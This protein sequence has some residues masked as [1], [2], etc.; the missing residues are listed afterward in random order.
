M[1]IL[2]IKRFGWRWTYIIMGLQA[3]IMGTLLLPFKNPKRGQYDIVSPEEEAQLL[4]QD[5]NDKAI[6]KPGLIDSVKDFYHQLKKVCENPVCRNIY[7]AGLIKATATCVITAFVPVFFQR[8][9][10]SFKSQ[11]A[12]LNAA[13]LIVC[14]FASSIIGGIIC[15]RYEKKS[16]MTKA[17][18]IMFGNFASIPLFAA[19]CF[20]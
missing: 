12:L 11:Y 4:A 1:S 20:S 3:I 15:D 14:G 13:C 7:K 10:P 19:I 16:Y 2:F 6:K 18:V 17:L 5:N 8:V 9:F